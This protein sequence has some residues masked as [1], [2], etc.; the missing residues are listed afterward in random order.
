MNKAPRFGGEPVSK[1]TAESTEN[2][3]GVSGD[4]ARYVFKVIAQDSEY[5]AHKHVLGIGTNNDRSPDSLFGQLEKRGISYTSAELTELS[6]IDDGSVEALAYVGVIEDSS[7]PAQVFKEMARVVKKRGHI[8]LTV[9]S[10]HKLDLL[11]IDHIKIR[12]TPAHLNEMSLDEWEKQW[13]AVGL[14]MDVSHSY[15]IGIASGL[16]HLPW[17]NE[18]MIPE[19]RGAETILTKYDETLD[20]YFFMNKIEKKMIESLQKG[21]VKSV[22]NELLKAIKKISLDRKERDV[23]KSFLE[24]AANKNTKYPRE[25]L[26]KLAKLFSS[27][28]HPELLLGNSIVT[29]LRPEE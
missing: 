13:E 21:D 12:K 16:A 25:H 23:C 26:E 11:N 9:P 7:D 19:A 28:R 3:W 20:N 6:I 4:H 18:A 14:S 5:Y 1:N 10:M 24:K 29:V 22:F 2:A 8:M 27:A 17:I 15:P